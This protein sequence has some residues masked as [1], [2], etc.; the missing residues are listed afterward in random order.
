MRV[1]VAV[2]CSTSLMVRIWSVDIKLH[3]K[4][5]PRAQELCESRG[6]RPGL[7]VPNS[8]YGLCGRKATLNCSIKE[9]RRCVKVEADVLGSPS[10][11]VRAVSVDI[12]LHMKKKNPRVQEMCESRGG[13]PGLPVPNS[14]YALCGRKAIFEIEESQS[15]EAV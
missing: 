11:I 5:Y 15:T 6:G 3:M 13:R 8:A 4:K 10:L 7:P 14:L 12:K 2:L 1:E 9:L